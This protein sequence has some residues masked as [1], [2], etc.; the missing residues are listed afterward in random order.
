[1]VVQRQVEQI[2]EIQRYRDIESNIKIFIEKHEL[3]NNKLQEYSK[4]STETFKG[5]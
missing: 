4:K 2:D 3:N 1:M 5:R